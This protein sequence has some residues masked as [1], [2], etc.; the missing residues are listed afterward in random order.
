M[1][2]SYLF[3][4]RPVNLSTPLDRLTGR[5]VDK[6]GLPIMPCTH[7]FTS[8]PVIPGRQVARSTDEQVRNTHNTMHSYIY[9]WTCQ[10]RLTGRQVDKNGLPIM[11]CTHIFT[12]R[13]VI[14]G[15]QVARSTDEQVRNTHYTM[16]SYIYRW[17]CQPWSPVHLSTCQPGLTGPD[18]NIGLQ[19]I[20]VSP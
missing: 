20:M 2:I 15:R 7:I 11:P 14:P 3:T 5:Q 6:N 16:H 9:R 10:P 13:P 17:T 1:G 18:V 4:C 19:D 12:S 8:R